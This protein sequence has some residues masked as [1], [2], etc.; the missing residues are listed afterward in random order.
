MK[1]TAITVFASVTATLAI[2]FGLRY[3]GVDVVGLLSVEKPHSIEQ[4]M[5][6]QAQRISTLSGTNVQVPM[7]GL[8]IPVNTG[9]RQSLLML[10]FYLYTAEENE[11]MLRK[12][13]P[14]IK[15]LNLKT[16]S[17]KPIEYYRDEAFVW[18]IQEDL[19]DLFKDE[20]QWRVNEVLITKA[21]Y[22]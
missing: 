9:R 1:K 19:R 15:N 2:L 3:A 6:T 20:R 16:F 18:N 22:Q 12:E 13:T 7:Q 5:L 21:V 4:V 14:K 10:D 11:K 8:I 17:V